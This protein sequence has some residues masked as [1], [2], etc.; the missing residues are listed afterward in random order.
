MTRTV[1]PD[2]GAPTFE[3]WRLYIELER[4]N[5][6]VRVARLARVQRHQKQH[7]DDETRMDRL[8]KHARWLVRHAEAYRNSRK[9]P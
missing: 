7:H 1:Y 6:Q 5:T 9:K 8:V 3:A 4:R 2:R